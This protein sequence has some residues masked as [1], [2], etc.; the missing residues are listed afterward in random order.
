MALDN[1]EYIWLLLG[2]PLFAG[3]ALMSH[4]TAAQWL[5]RFAR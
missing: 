4:L 3:C 1:P 5:V 2:V